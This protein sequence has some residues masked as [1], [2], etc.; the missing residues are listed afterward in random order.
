MQIELRA[1]YGEQTR[2]VPWLLDEVRSTPPHRFDRELDAA[3]CGHD[4]DGH[5]QTI[6][7]DLR[8]QIDALRARRGVARVV[9]V[10]QDGIVAL[11]C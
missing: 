5:A 9:H 6:A 11:A 2:V 10:H 4:D 1:Q 8:Q 3:P 7:L